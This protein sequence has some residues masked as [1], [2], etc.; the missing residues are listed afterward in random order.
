MASTSEGF[1]RIRYLGANQGALGGIHQRSMHGLQY[2]ALHYAAPL[3]RLAV[4]AQKV[5]AGAH[6][7][8]RDERDGTMYGR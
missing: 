3:S 4:A 8:S 1:A 5:P 6:E 2:S 7:V